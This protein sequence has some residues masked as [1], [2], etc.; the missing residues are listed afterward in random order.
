M[1]EEL[2]DYFI[3]KRFWEKLGMTKNDIEKLTFN[4]FEML[5]QIMIIEDQHEQKEIKKAQ[6]KK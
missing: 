3:L 4:K 2:N 5:N 6:K 1:T